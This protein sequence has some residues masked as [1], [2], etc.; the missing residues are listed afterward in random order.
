MNGTAMAATR[1][2]RERAQVIQGRR[3]GWV[4]L[5]VGMGDLGCEDKKKSHRNPFGVA[6]SPK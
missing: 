1:N 4:E 2:S 5:G 3:A 6:Q